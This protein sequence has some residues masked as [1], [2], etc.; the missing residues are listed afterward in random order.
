M[1]NYVQYYGVDAPPP[2]RIMLNAGSVSMIFEPDLG[3]LRY[4]KL[5]ETEILRGL[6]VA[7]RDHNWD[8][9]APQIDNVNLEQDD[10]GFELTFDVVCVERD[11][12]FFW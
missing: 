11:I 12:D 2:E 3:F 1:G 6:Y 5:G 9:I 4:I 7:V 10:Q 8:T